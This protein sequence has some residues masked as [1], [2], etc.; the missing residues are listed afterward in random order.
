MRQNLFISP[1]LASS[2]SFENEILSL[3]N[4][5]RNSDREIKANTDPKTL[6]DIISDRLIEVVKKE[7][8]AN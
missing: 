6:A 8:N 2:R 1:S 4:K 7:I 3:F 5:K